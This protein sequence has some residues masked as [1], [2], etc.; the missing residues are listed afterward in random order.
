MPKPKSIVVLPFANLSTSNENEFFSD[1]ITEEIINALTR[2]P[3]LRVTSRTS[4]FYFKNKHLPVTNI[5]Q[6]LNVALLLE[7]S[8]RLAGDQ[9]RITAQLIDA[10][11]DVHLWSETW[12]R[13]VD[14]IFDIQDE[15][16]LLVA[17]KAREFLGHFDIQA[18]LI[19]PQTQS[20]QAYE[21]YLKGRFY[22]RKWNPEDAQKSVTCFEQALK[23]DPH[24]AESLLGLADAL[25][26][27]A[28]TGAMEH[29][30]A[31]QRA[32]V[33]INQALVINHQLPEAHYQR[34]NLLFF[35]QGN[36][37]MAVQAA[38]QAHK[39]N[40]NYAEANQHLTFLYLIAGNNIEA[41]AHLDQLLMF[42]PLSQETRFF[43]AFFLYQQHH[44]AQSLDI[45]NQSLQTNQLNVPAHTLKCYCLLKLGRADEV[46]GYFDELP[47]GIMV[48]GDKLG[49]EALRYAFRQDTTN[50]YRVLKALEERAKLPAGFRENSFLLFVYAVLHQTDKAFAWVSAELEKKSP[51]LLMHYSDV[52]VDDLKT[53]PRYEVFRKKIYA[54][55]TGN[56]ADKP[57]KKPLI[58][59]AEVEEYAQKLRMYLINEKP[60]LD[61]NLSLK[62]LAK[63][64]GM[65]ANQLSWLINEKMGENFNQLINSYRVQQFKQLAQNPA[66]AHLSIIG[67]AFESGFNSKTVFNTYFKKETGLTPKQWIKAL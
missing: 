46:K 14:H 16:S 53:D 3:G 26:F 18:Q 42:D 29:A 39:L 37:S 31:W 66:N 27:L 44:F 58:A 57:P 41:K 52:M 49:V 30:T 35:T 11:E 43:H 7:G 50:T 33:C 67:L 22:F 10:A 17:D 55:K 59:E 34:S 28:T 19:N 20:Y 8:V 54:V 61:N 60:Y 9:M 2:I 1:G 32:E 40:P 64:L 62:L 6:Q 4:S 45:L 51:F 13:K 24:H 65:H 36:Y 56:N 21:W 48:E 63:A 5:G 38:V 23:L 47:P 15:V 25:G 12:D